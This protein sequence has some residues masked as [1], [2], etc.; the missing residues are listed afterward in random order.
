MGL[1]ATLLIATGCSVSGGPTVPAS[2]SPQAL[3]DL[4][5][6]GLQVPAE[7]AVAPFDSPH[8]VRVPTGWTVSLWAR[9]PNARLAAWAPDGELLISRPGIG[10]VVAL[11]PSDSGGPTQRTVASGLRQPHG[12]AFAGRILYIAESNQVNAF[13]YAD[14][15]VSNR[16]IVVADLPDSKTPE[17]GGAY[18]H[19]LKSVAVGTDGALYVSVGSSG[20]ISAGDW[21]A[22][23]ERASILRIPPGGGAARVYARGVRNG[24]GLAI[25]PDGAVWTAVNDRDNLGYP[26]HRDYDGEGTD[27]Y[28][29]VMQAYV[30]DHPMEAIAKLFAGR[31]LGWPHCNPD[32][33]L[34]PGVS[35]R[36][37]GY[38]DRPL[39]GDMQTNADGSLLDCAALP[40]IE[41]G[42]PAHSAP[43]GMSFVTGPGL[44]SPFGAGVLIASH[45]SWNRRPPQTPEVS[46]FPWHDGGL[47]DRVVF[48][49]GFQ[50]DDG[51]AGDGR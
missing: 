16:R 29:S 11:R 39:I 28:G 1:A 27:D 5:S 37:T 3:S 21:T 20:N 10:D 30:N 12:L 45:G 33:D 7:L 19:A 41:Q 2:T 4:Q 43:L 8:T 38:A 22:T 32:P 15:A 14:G 40:P 44:P 50:G 42:L 35:G 25:A 26:Y 47:G 6:T 24:T 17:L 34:Q 48:L 46:F 23:P 49:T 13:D 18:A 31:D 51:H 36:L 9:L